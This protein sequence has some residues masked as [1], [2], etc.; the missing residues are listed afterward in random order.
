MKETV[1]KGQSVDI[2]WNDMTSVIREDLYESMHSAISEA[3][4]CIMSFDCKS[5]AKEVA[6]GYRTS[7]LLIQP[8]VHPA[9]QVIERKRDTKTV[10]KKKSTNKNFRVCLYFF[11]RSC[12]AAF[13]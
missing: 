7:T 6:A 4:H 11:L 1:E 2:N 9:P 8:L 12:L 13:V 3:K 10:K 5:A